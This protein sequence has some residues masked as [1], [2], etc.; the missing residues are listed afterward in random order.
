MALTSQMVP[1]MTLDTK[2]HTPTMVAKVAS[3]LF[4]SCTAQQPGRYSSCGQPQMQPPVVDQCL[5]DSGAG[6]AAI[7]Q[8]V[9]PRT[10]Q[11]ETARSEVYREQDGLERGHVPQNQ[12]PS[13]HADP[14]KPQ[15][16]GQHPASL[17]ISF[18]GLKICL[19]VSCLW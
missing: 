17:P 19:D 3:R 13:I 12:V 16:H 8:D 1:I 2:A 11:L 4:L 9:G 7:Q 5:T 15:T 14:C 10:G 6:L 18:W